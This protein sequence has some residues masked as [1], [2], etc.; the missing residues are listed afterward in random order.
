V[1]NAEG[2]TTEDILVY[3]KKRGD[4]RLNFYFSPHMVDWGAFNFSST[5]LE[6]AMSQSELIRRTQE[7]ATRYISRSKVR[8]SSELTMMRQAM[9]SKTPIP[10]TIST[11]C[12]TITGKGS[13]MEYTAILQQAQ[14]CAICADPPRETGVTLPCI[15]YNKSL[16]PFAQ[17][18]PA[19]AYI[20]SCTPG[21]NTYFPPKPSTC[22]N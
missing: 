2:V 16:P 13:Q 12:A 1:L 8:D 22:C 4:L 6:M 5:K 11:C 9:A 10:Q 7:E 19:N 15:N 20:P 3:D 14:G 18:D 21:F 17:Q